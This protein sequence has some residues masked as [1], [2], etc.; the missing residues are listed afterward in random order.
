MKSLHSWI[1]LVEVDRRLS[2]FG[3]L[4]GAAFELINKEIGAQGQE[5]DMK[6]KSSG[7]C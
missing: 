2:I 4:Y 7:V 5:G 6:I 3:S 1:L